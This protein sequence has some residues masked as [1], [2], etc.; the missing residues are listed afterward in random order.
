MESRNLFRKMKLEKRKLIHF[1]FSIFHT[2]FCF[3]LTIFSTVTTS[4]EEVVQ[5]S[6]APGVRKFEIVDLGVLLKNLLGVAVVSAAILCLGY[7]IWGAIDWIM[8]EGEQE[9]LKNAKN[10]VTHALMGLALM[11]LVWLIW[12]L[13]IYFLGLGVIEKG[14]VKLPFGD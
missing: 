10:K 5:P 13:T 6:A 7:L 12:R 2:L 9:K 4:I 14:Q 8:S 1:P 3:P 11:A